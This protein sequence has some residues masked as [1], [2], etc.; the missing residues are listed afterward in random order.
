MDY[1][2]G[3]IEQLIA[4]NALN[5]T[6]AYM[7]EEDK[8]MLVWDAVAQ[9]LPVLFYNWEPRAPILGLP[10][11]LF[12][13]VE[14]TPS[15][16]GCPDPGSD[17]AGPARCDEPPVLLQKIASP[18]LADSDDARHFVSNFRLTSEDYA[19]LFQHFERAGRDPE[20]AACQWLKTKGRDHWGEWAKYT[21]TYIPL[22]H[23]QGFTG[24]WTAVWVQGGLLLLVSML[25]YGKAL[26]WSWR[27]NHRGSNRLPSIIHIRTVDMESQDT[28]SQ[29]TE[30]QDTKTLEDCDTSKMSR[31]WGH[32]SDF[33]KAVLKGQ[34]SFLGFQRKERNLT[35][36]EGSF[37][38]VPQH[39]YD[40]FRM[41]TGALQMALWYLVKSQ[42]WST[43]VTT[44]QNVLAVGTLG[45]LVHLWREQAEQY[46]I[47]GEKEWT[48]S[49]G[50]QMGELVN[51]FKGLPTLFIIFKVMADIKRWSRWLGYA[52]SVCGRL[53]DIALIISSLD[54]ANGPDD[55]LRVRRLQFQFYRYL[56]LAHLLA[57]VEIDYRIPTEPR[58]LSAALVRT[59]LLLEEEQGKLVASE[60]GGMHLIVMAWIAG[61]WHTEIEGR[62]DPGDNHPHAQNF[63]EKLMALRSTI[64][65]LRAHSDFD[66]EPGVS[67]GI[68]EMI[69]YAF[70]FLLLITY[71][72]SHY[73][74]MSQCVQI[75]PMLSASLFVFVYHA[76][77][78]MQRMLQRSPF[79]P[80]GECVNTDNLLVYSEEMLFYMIRANH[81]AIDVQNQATPVSEFYL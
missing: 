73:S 42:M 18:K 17:P 58:E 57:Y 52:G 34:L 21:P 19:E 48:S 71:P 77:I 20:E 54:G 76:L 2:L 30:S 25:R 66:R 69:I 12:R 11:S 50:N 29:D 81:A 8:E 45:T 32:G 37:Y 43:I 79:D 74:P 80:R 40:V 3:V 60:R 33:Q 5:V 47:P 51:D 35:M 6:V 24:C 31:I 15:T 38:H 67:N 65:A 28:E 22:L 16:A 41:Q 44:A 78:N 61:L 64:G 56:N 14:F 53:S 55:G 4:N 39:G 70:L 9:G 46:R 36:D 62:Q 1:Q 59:G 72:F 10:A 23:V 68:M 27:G 63:M 13:R 26:L 75:W 7:T 49:F